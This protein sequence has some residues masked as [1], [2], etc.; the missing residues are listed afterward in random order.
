MS[1][2]QEKA[3]NHSRGFFVFGI[4]MRL[5]VVKR[6]H[7]L[8]LRASWEDSSVGLVPRGPL[9]NPGCEQPE[10]PNF[11]CHALRVT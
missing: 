11:V 8:A 4:F 1:R 7:S 5:V 2:W 9:V 10:V 3:F 6:I